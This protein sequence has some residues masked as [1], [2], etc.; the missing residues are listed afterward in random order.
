MTDWVDL[1]SDTVTRPTLA[2]REAGLRAEVGDDVFGDDPSVNA[3]QD[4][5]AAD[6]GFEA[7]LFLPS[8][9]QSNLAALM[10]HCERGDEY[11]VGMD[12]H[13]YK[14]E[15]GGAAVL[16]SIQP[17][18]IVQAEDGTLPLDKLA[19]AVKPL[20]DPHYARTR[21]LALENTWHGRPLPLPYLAQAA[22]FARSRGLAYHL[23][24]ARLFNAAVACGVPARE[25]TRHF[26]SVSVCLSKGLGAPAGSVLVGSHEVVAKARR[27]RKV[28]GGGWRQAGLLAAMATH[29]L[30]HHV[31]RLAEDHRRAREL[32]DAL[33][34]LPGVSVETPHTNLVFITVPAD[35]GKPLAEFLLAQGVRIAGTGPRIRLVTHL[36]IDDEGLARAI[37]AFR[38][39]FAG[40]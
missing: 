16:G 2:M 20:G 39:F 25:I 18:P 29:A 37:A 33:G 32:A 35:A 1:R 24:G 21:L 12:A 26:D 17:Q 14:Y 30:D 23:D 31:A 7:G 13:T 6:L 11:L 10:A 19:G 4:R 5:L 27:W 38:A 3:L 36:D 22:E 9:T 28:L 40:R 15:G 8:G 34:A